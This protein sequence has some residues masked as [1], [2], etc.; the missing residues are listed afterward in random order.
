MNDQCRLGL[1][2]YSGKA[3]ELSRKAGLFEF[4]LRRWRH[5]DQSEARARCLLRASPFPPSNSGFL[6][7]PSCL[8]ADRG[9][10]ALR[11]AVLAFELNEQALSL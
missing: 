4:R 9:S 3:F 1:P 7:N 6:S 8:N 2:E 5:P 11:M 10:Y